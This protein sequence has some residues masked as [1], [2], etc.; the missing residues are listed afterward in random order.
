MKGKKRF[1]T[2]VV[3]TSKSVE[4]EMPWTRGARRQIFISRRNSLVYE[5][6]SA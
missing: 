6:K 5:P 2:A 1:L 4:A 3:K